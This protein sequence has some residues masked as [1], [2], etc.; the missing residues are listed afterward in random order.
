MSTEDLG[1]NGFN[2]EDCKVKERLLE[3]EVKKRSELIC[4]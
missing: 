4:S 3:I 2:T 1:D